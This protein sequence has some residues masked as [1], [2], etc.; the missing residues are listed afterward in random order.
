MGTLGIAFFGIAIHCLF[1]TLSAA[2]VEKSKTHLSKHD[3]VDV[4][5]VEQ[6][7][8]MVLNLVESEESLSLI[9]TDESSDLDEPDAK[10][11]PTPLTPSKLKPDTAAKSAKNEAASPKRDPNHDFFKG[12]FDDITAMF[13]K[14]GYTVY[15]FFTTL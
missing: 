13:K 2:S 1:S 4:Q 8:P 7:D 10:K 14:A 12:F 3:K 9:D 6:A 15:N 11:A 5:L